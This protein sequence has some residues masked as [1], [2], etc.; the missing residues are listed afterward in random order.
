MKTYTRI[1]E[2]EASKIQSILRDMEPR[3]YSAADGWIIKTED[4]E[5]IHVSRE[6]QTE[7]RAR[8]GGYIVKAG[9]KLFAMGA[10]R[11][12]AT[13][14]TTDAPVGIPVPEITER[15]GDTFFDFESITRPVIE[16]LNDNAN[17][18]SQVLIT[19]DSASMSSDLVAYTTQDYIKD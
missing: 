13:Y 3:K 17:A 4:D 14:S 11:F 18:H 10:T 19:V 12:E 7:N 15:K 1:E 2:V 6:W 8:C 5:E 16:W 9:A